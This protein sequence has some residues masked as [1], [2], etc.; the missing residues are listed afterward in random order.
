MEKREYTRTTLMTQT[1]VV[2][3]KTHTDESCSND[4]QYSQSKDEEQC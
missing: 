4:L 2:V 1:L 3:S